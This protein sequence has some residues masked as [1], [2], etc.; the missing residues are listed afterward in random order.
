MGNLGDGISLAAGP[1]LVASETHDPLK[2]AAAAVL[3]RLPWLLFG[4]L[5]GV[6]ADR[7]DRRR[8]MVAVHLCRAAIAALIA[9]LVLTGRIDIAVLLI[10]LFLLGTTEV[11]ADTTAGTLLP[12]I[13]TRDDLGLANARLVAGL[14]TVDQLA[15][16]T[17]GAAFFIAG[18]A[19]PF[20]AEAVCMV[21][22]AVLASRLALGASGPPARQAVRHDIVEGFRWL[23][24]HAAIRTLT[25]TI[26]VFN[27]TFGAAWSVL[28]LYALNRLHAGKIGFGLLTTAT[29]VGGL[30]G[31]AIYQ[32]ITARVGLGN[33]MRIGLI[34]ETL[35]H[36]SLAVTRSTGVALVVM[37]VFGIHAQVWGVT[38]TS[39]RQ[40]AV[41]TRL[42]GRVTSVYLIGVQAG[43][44]AGGALG[45]VIAER[46]GVTGPFWFAFVGSAAFL[47]L[48]WRQLPNVVH[49]EEPV[50]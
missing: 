34:I 37:F 6:V 40:R 46:Y 14:I 2:V 5:A 20:V 38:S 47:V 7:V 10:C 18:R 12:M 41:P 50:S 1:L 15:G 45:G 31:A 29:A 17:I 11:L 3:Q 30:F 35:T 19:I 33:I 24:R 26:V 25:V 21:I 4:L 8:I 39:V 16:P 48:I 23:W 42:Q 36:L 9:T 49:A 22:A 32:R 13:V 44:V 43:I 27:V 28:V